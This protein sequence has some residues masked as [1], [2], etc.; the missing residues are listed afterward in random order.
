MKLYLQKWSFALVLL[1]WPPLPALSLCLKKYNLCVTQG[2]DF[3]INL[4]NHVTFL[5]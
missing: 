5:I 1:F 2:P 3:M 4:I